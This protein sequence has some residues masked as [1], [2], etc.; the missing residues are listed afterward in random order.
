MAGFLFLRARGHRLLLAAA[1]LAILLTT[2]ILAALAAF[3]GSVGDAGLRHALRTRDASAAALVITSENTEVNRTAAARDARRGAQLAFDGLPVKLQ[4]FDRSGPYALPR[5]LQ[6]PAAR[7]GEPDLTLFAAV[8][9]AHVRLSSGTW[10]T[11]KT[12]GV[13]PVALPEVAAKQLRLT[14]GPRVLKVTDRMGGPP[15]RIRVTGIYRPTDRGAPYWQ[16]DELDGRGVTKDVFTTFGPL[17]TDPSAMG[18]GGIRPGGVSWL[19]T[20]DFGGLTGE[21]IDGV[22]KASAKSQQL[23]SAQPS[24]ATGVVARTS[25]PGVLDQLERALLVSRAT[26]LLVSLQLVLLAGYALLLVA[27]LL[28]QER[29]SE[30]QVL[31]ARGA[32][33][34]RIASLAALEALLLALPAAVCAP[35]L[36]GPITG[37]LAGHGLLARIGLQDELAGSGPTVRLWF[38]GAAVALACAV[39]VTMPALTAARAARG[40]ARTLP[41]PLRAGADIALLA[42][43]GVAYWQLE[44]RTSGSGA[45]SGDREGRLGIDPLLVVA[46]AL[47][48]LAGTVLT[49]RLLPPAARLAERRA[50]RGRGLTTSLAGWQFSRRPMRGA[51]PVLLLVLSVA[52]GMLAIGQGASWDRSQDDQAD[53]RTGAPVRVL[54]GGSVPGF[55]QGGLY[56]GMRG[57]R[58][59]AP[60]ARTEL[61]LSG[62][63]RSTVLALD[64]AAAAEGLQLRGDLTGG[65]AGRPLEALRPSGDARPGVLLPKDVARLEFDVTL[66]RPSTRSGGEPS[67]GPALTFTFEDRYGVSYRIPVDPPP[68]DGRPHRVSIDLARAAGGPAGKPAAPLALTDIEAFEAEAADR[69][70]SKRLAFGALR[71]VAADGTSRAVALPS[72]FAWTVKAIASVEVD[73]SNTDEAAPAITAVRSS[74]RK[75]LDISYHTGKTFL[76]GWGPEMTVTLRMTVKRSAPAILKALVTEGF[77]QASGAKVGAVID[78]PMQGGAVRVQIMGVLGAIPTTE[79]E[80]S[81]GGTTSAEGGSEAAS[82]AKTDGGA[83]LVDLRAVNQILATRI[84]AAFPPSEWW[85]FP[86]PGKVAETAAKIRERTDLEPNQIQVRDEMAAALHSDPLGAGPQSALLAATIAA[87]ALAAVGFAVSAVGALRERSREFAVLRALGAPRRQLARLLALEQSLLIGLALLIGVALGTVLTRAVVPL[88]VLTGQATQPIPSVLVEL[89]TDRVAL[90]LVGV[91]ATPVAIVLALALRRGD[92]LTALRA[93]G[94]E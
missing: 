37:L 66:R 4:Q 5:T 20:A 81:I 42:I 7:K 79:R 45:L 13:I 72:G 58:S 52:M 53:F 84:D 27:R 77:L 89:P 46:P 60:A 9:R 65:G 25:L 90:L 29:S 87:A 62:G 19:A 50:A 30:T 75:P 10:P 82:A 1:L 31:L 17:L 61:S 85:L 73:P 56:D 71:S 67:S 23:L 91:A 70:V 22:R 49:L 34:R 78:L 48:L 21:R 69:I 83:L 74:A 41:G 28:S 15:V 33:R 76:D 2:S 39:A 80:P 3:A 38:I 6:S 94:G 43:A 12:A 44:R 55:G 68:G 86:L 26:L 51:G 63:R 92:S 93:Q 57:V 64:T 24:L 47:A 59:V 36:A 16:L 35:L 11:P 54:S 32:S 88:I 18:T 8:D 40:R 14:P